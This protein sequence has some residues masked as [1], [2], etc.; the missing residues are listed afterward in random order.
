MQGK[1]CVSE[2]N[3]LLLTLIMTLDSS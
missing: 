3:V 1:D 2:K